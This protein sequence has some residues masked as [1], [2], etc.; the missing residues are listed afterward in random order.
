M[1][2]RTFIFIVGISMVLAACSGKAGSAASPPG[3]STVSK[4][5]SVDEPLSMNL[6]VALNLTT[7]TDAKPS[8]FASYHIE[9]TLNLPKAN[10]NYSAVVSEV[11][12]I[13]ADVQG[14]NIHI[15]QIDPGTTTPKEGFII[16]D[17]GKEYKMAN[18]APQETIGTVALS[19]S[20][21]RLDVVTPYAFGT[22]LHAEKTGEESVNGRSAV[23][24]DF[25]SSKGDPGALAAMSTGVIGLSQSKGTVWI[26]K[27]TGGMLK[28]TLDYV[29]RVSNKDGTTSIG[30]GDGHI[31]LEISNVNQTTVTSPV[32]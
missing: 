6:G 12:K 26:D 20:F 9:I 29:T 13:S 10:S 22:V 28:L 2:K 17:A 15:F 27:I 5:T 8:V 4:G 3:S 31:Q 14:K 30:E 25:D 18:G 11:T 32:K 7:G 24:Y 16:G 23:V 1:F 21:W 19:W